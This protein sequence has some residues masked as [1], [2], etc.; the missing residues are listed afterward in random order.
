[1]I[2]TFRKWLMSVAVTGSILLANQASAALSVSYTTS[3][4]VPIT[5]TEWVDVPLSFQ[6]FNPALGTLE[7][8]TLDFSSSMSTTLTVNNTA[9]SGYSSGHAATELWIM[10]HD[11][12]NNLIPLTIDSTSPTFNFVRLG[13]GQITT[14]GPLTQSGSGSHTYTLPGVLTEFTGAGNFSLLVNTMTQTHLR[15]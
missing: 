8:V 12:G 13:P 15:Q 9:S 7:S 6:Q 1:M 4:P 11:G 2:V 14:S 3:P 5:S 10:V